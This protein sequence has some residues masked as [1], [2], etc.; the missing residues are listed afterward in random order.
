[1]GQRD[2]C[3][4]C[5]AAQYF[6]RSSGFAG[7]VKSQRILIA[8]DAW[9]PQVN[10]VVRTLENLVRKLRDGGHTVEAVTPDRFMNLPLA[11]YP[12]I[13][14]AFA[15]KRSLAAAIEKFAPDRI[16]IAVEGPIGWA[17]RA[18]CLGAGLPF[19]TSYHTRFPEYLRA[20]APVPLSLSYRVLRHFHAPARATLVATASVTRELHLRGFSRLRVWTRGVDRALF[21]PRPDDGLQRAL[22]LRRPVFC[23]VG[24]IS[25][26]KNIEAFLA[27]DLP[28][29]KLVVGDGPARAALQAAYP[30]ANFVGAKHGEELARHYALADVFVFPSL[31]DTFGNV[32]LEALACGVP[33]AAYP[34]PGPADILTGS[35][36]GVLGDD[37]RAAALAALAVP[38]EAALAHAARFTWSECARQFLDA[39]S[40]ADASIPLA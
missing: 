15:G 31:T 37:L 39:G 19:T 17:T 18:A 24:R 20:R 38:R 29:S 8:S 28:G 36:A 27:L 21:R 2:Q 13:R 35:G 30:A 40:G 9:R 6:R 12:E 5:G 11:G 3:A 7:R 34:A 23:H 14:L 33:V 1:L 32:I 25:V 16:H 10:G 26:E 22:G 4:Q